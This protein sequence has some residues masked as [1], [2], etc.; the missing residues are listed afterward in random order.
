[1]Q[2]ELDT[3]KAEAESERTRISEAVDGFRTQFAADQEGQAQRFE[4]LRT[5]LGK[6]AAEAIERLNA[7]TTTAAESQQA[8]AESA[9]AEL[10][11]RGEAVIADLDELREKAARL[12]DLVA[13]SST[14][15][16]FGKEAKAQRDE[17]DSWR[18]NAVRLG[19]L[20]VAVA[21]VAIAANFVVDT[22]PSLIVAKVA[23]IALIL[24]VAGYAAGQSGQHRLRE[25]RAKR[26]ELELVAFGPFA[27]PLG[28]E[29]KLEVRKEFI[30]RLF[31]GDP[32][33]EP[34]PGDLRLNEES[35]SLLRRLV[36]ALRGS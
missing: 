14:A 33:N 27:E 26:L 3:L 6:D 31:V 16:A 7:A 9:L 28:D 36:D 20:A 22:P 34:A 19:V 29:A 23:A 11:E 18:W 21:L 13:T 5:E 8:A 4:E 25:Q 15:G 12:V 30:D 2:A 17:A 32:G 35:V 1:M 24:G 10:T